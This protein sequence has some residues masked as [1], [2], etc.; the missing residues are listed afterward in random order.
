[1]L[2][3]EIPYHLRNTVEHLELP[4]YI[5]L[6]AGACRPPLHLALGDTLMVLGLVRNQGRPLKLHLDPGPARELVEAHP[7]VRELITKPDRPSGLALTRLPVERSGRGATWFSATTHRLALPVLPVDRV[8]ANPILAHSLYYDLKNQDDRPSVFLDPGRPWALK[9]LLS[10]Q[11]PT[12]VVY[13]RN[14]SRKSP[15][16]RD[17][18]WWRRLLTQLG[19]QYALVAVGAS[20][21]GELAGAVDVC[22][23]MDDPGSTLLDLAWLMAK[24]AG[25]VGVDGGLSHLAAAV[26]ARPVTVWD[27]MGSYRFWAGQG[28]HHLI[29]SNPYGYRYPQA[30]RMTWQ[31]I[32]DRVRRVWA[33]DGQGGLQEVEM[34]Q[35]G[36]LA[37]AVEL[38]G[39]EELFTAA[40]LAQREV[41]DDRAGVTIWYTQARMREAF[42][43]QSLDFAIRAVTGQLA[44]GSNWVAPVMA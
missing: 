8:R 25:F 9:D 35:E 33:P 2:I 29:M 42:H 36:Y 20:D 4:I 27:S 24:A 40:A 7:L 17:I 39:S 38:F 28:G 14:P 32:T 6:Q 30:C 5:E 31:E 12:L 23:P 19:Q 44:P 22:L 10:G 26:T 3:Q 15:F 13:P 34:P 16:W 1:M 11:R 37:R 41:E 21:Y 18:R 43:Q